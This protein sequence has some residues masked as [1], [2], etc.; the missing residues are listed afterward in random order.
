MIRKANQSDLRAIALV[1]LEA[2]LVSAIGTPRESLV[3]ATPLETKMKAWAT[4]F[5]DP[6]ISV[7]V[8]EEQKVVRGFS[9]FG[10][11]RESESPS[12]DVGEI[13]TIFVLPRHW[14][15]GGM[16]RTSLK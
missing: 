11:F 10:A 5:N 15:Q 4:V 6:S 12:K 7:I 16:S 3:Q 1:H 13:H 9:T 2:E 14:G 8:D